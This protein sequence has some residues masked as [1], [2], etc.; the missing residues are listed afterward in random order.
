MGLAGRS[1]RFIKRNFVYLILLSVVATTVC[2]WVAVAS[3]R[4]ADENFLTGWILLGSM[5]FLA[6][7]NVRK[8][9]PM[10]PLGSAALW[11][12]MHV[13]VGWF[14]LGLFVAHNGLD[15]PNGVLEI[16]LATLFLAVALSGI[17]GLVISRVFAKRLTT[18]G[19]EVIFERIPE[20]RE[21]LRQQA[22]DVALQSISASGS[23]TLADFYAV[24]LKQTFDGPRNFLGHVF[25]SQRASFALQNE[26]SALGR[27]LNENDLGYQQEL[28]DLVHRK[29]DL[30]RHYALQAMLKCWLF[31]HIPLTYSLLIVTVVHV[32]IVYAYSGTS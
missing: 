22:E 19:E 4:L 21:R 31:V 11:L 9:L 12:N 30:D 15:L 23:T 17:F 1:L 14:C 29:A 26:I 24:R 28:T 6:L 10:I 25:G 7:F 2:L 8:K 5:I 32:V 13:Y 18:F 20:F 16:T 27:Y 3:A